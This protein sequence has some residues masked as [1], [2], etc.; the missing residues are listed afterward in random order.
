MTDGPDRASRLAQKLAEE[1]LFGED[2][3]DHPDVI[4][5]AER[6][7]REFLVFES[8]SPEAR[9]PWRPI[10]QPPDTAQTVLLTNGYNVS[11]GYFAAT[12]RTPRWHD[13][14]MQHYSDLA[15]AWMPPPAPPDTK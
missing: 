10:D 8:R 12:D 1:E 6:V 13:P 14:V 5:E 2:V 11:S 7:I 15:I 4:A 3:F 9:S